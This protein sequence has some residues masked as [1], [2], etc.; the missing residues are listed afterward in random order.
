VYKRQ[1]NDVTGISGSSILYIIGG[2]G[3]S[4]SGSGFGSKDAENVSVLL[5]GKTYTMDMWNN[6][7]VTLYVQDGMATSGL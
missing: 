3:D 6:G 1:T 7:G 2:I 4:V 5:N